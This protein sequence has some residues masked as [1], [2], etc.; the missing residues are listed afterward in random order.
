MDVTHPVKDNTLKLEIRYGRKKA[1]DRGG[2]GVNC[3]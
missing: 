1:K 3:M 2:K